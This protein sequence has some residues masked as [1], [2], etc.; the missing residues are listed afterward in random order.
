MTL[1]QFSNLPDTG[2]QHEMNAGELLTF[3]PAKSSHA[4]V[5]TKLLKILLDYLQDKEL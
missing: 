5:S 4:R 2:V 3:P 1:S